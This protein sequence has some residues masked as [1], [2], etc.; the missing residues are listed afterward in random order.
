M[1]RALLATPGIQEPVFLVEIQCP[2]TVIGSVY[3]VL[4]KR[5]GQIF[6]EEQRVGTLMFNVKAYLLSWSRLAS[7]VIYKRSRGL[8]L[9]IGNL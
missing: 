7:T 5:R 4:N 3:S 1:V 8:C 2:D 6:S 9:I